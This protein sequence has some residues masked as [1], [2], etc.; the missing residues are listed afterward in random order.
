MHGVR[1]VDGFARAVHAHWDEIL[2]Y[3]L[4]FS[5][6]TGAWSR[7]FEKH[8]VVLLPQAL[9]MGNYSVVTCTP[10]I[11]DTLP[12]LTRT[13]GCGRAPNTSSHANTHPEESP[14]GPRHVAGGA[15]QLSPAACSAVRQLYATD[16]ALW[17]R[18]CT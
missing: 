13:L 18:H 6:R 1:H 16:T 5:R 7:G 14:H 8:S 12:Q 17:Q 2:G 4:S 11:D 10:R 15:F 3:Q 9:W